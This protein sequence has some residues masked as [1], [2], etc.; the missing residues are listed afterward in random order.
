MEMLNNVGIEISHCFDKEYID[1]NMSG[2]LNSLG[3][4]INFSEDTWLC[5]KNKNSTGRESTLKIYF[6][7]ISREYLVFIKYYV[8]I[9]TKKLSSIQSDVKNI[10][11][12]CKYLIA[13]ESSLALNNVTQATIARYR[14]HVDKRDVVKSTKVKY[15]QSVASF[16][17]K[18]EG[19]EGIPINNP[20]NKRVHLYKRK[21]SDNELKTRY[22]PDSVAQQLDELFLT[23]EIPIHFRLFY[24]FCRLYPSRCSEISLLG[25]DCIKPLD[26]YYVWF[27]E[28]EK[29]S[30]DIGGPNLLQIYIKYEN[31]GK[32][33]VDLYLEQKLIAQTLEIKAKEKLKGRLFLYNPKGKGNT[34]QNKI[35]LVNGTI[36]N[37]FLKRLCKEEKLI[38]G[39]ENDIKITTHSFRHNAITDRLYEEFSVT[40]IRDLTGQKGDGEVIDSYHHRKKDEVEKIQRKT[41]KERFPK[42]KPYKDIENQKSNKDITLPSS[43]VIFRGRIINLDDDTEKRILANKRAYKISYSDK[44]VGICTEIA[45]CNSGIF[46][47]FKCDEF[48]PDSSEL[49]FFKEQVNYWEEKLEYFQLQGN[50]YQMEHA[51][52]VKELFEIIVRKIEHINKETGEML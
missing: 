41:L 22:I 8:L 44:S 46:D 14:K 42:D 52:E 50:K 5:D 39:I 47:C 23:E 1:E 10:G 2:M 51:I 38:Q 3:S 37:A 27:K 17:W 26:N 29:S 19:W 13:H 4:D 43:K 30:N 6:P 7:K 25:K 49:P 16:F 9:S 15:M 20:V 45:S 24:W 32:Y 11:M 21:K 12:F 36:F 28:E 40:S 33:L 48:A 18:L 35:C 34:K 31:M